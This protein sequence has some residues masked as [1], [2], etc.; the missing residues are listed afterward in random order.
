MLHGA[1]YVHYLLEKRQNRSNG[2]LHPHGGAVFHVHTDYHHLHVCY[3][4]FCLRNW[5]WPGQHCPLVDV[6][7]NSYKKLQYRESI[8]EP[9]EYLLYVNN[10]HQWRRSLNVCNQF[11]TVSFH[12]HILVVNLAVNECIS[13]MI[14]TY[15]NYLFMAN[16][17]S[18]KYNE[19]TIITH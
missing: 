19:S 8:N 14:A 17:H 5:P 16:L 1:A 9:W 4:C 10:K 18:G 11:F 2:I 3:C 6:L 13:I 12:F 7:L 15:C